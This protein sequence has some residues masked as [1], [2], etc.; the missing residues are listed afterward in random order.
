VPKPSS[1][2]PG[3]RAASQSPNFGARIR[4]A[5]LELLASQPNGLR[6]SDLVRHV[7]KLNPAFNNKTV[8]NVVWSLDTALPERVYK[9][10][11]GVYRL[12]E[13]REATDDSASEVPVLA[14]HKGG[15]EEEFYPLFARWLK[16]EVEDVTFAIPLGGNAFRDMRI[17]AI[18]DTRFALI[19][20]TVSR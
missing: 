7:S 17:S 9:P 14:K 20:D 11:K 4:S 5:A 12:V 8:S 13:F 2:S 19:A 10:S 1:T 3:A 15:R 18:A 6:Y 16:N